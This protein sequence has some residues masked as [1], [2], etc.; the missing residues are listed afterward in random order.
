MSLKI[1]LLTIILGCLVMTVLFSFLFLV[2]CPSVPV[3]MAIPLM[4]VSSIFTIVPLFMKRAEGRIHFFAS[5]A[6]LF[7]LGVIVTMVSLHLA[8]FWWPSCIIMDL[9][10]DIAAVYLDHQ[11]SGPYPG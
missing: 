5:S 4:I 9:C 8:V 11:N 2:V 7:I 10:I 3:E 6:F 1:S